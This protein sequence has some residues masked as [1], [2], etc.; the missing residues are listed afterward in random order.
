LESTSVRTA[1][2][3]FYGDTG[4]YP[5]AL[6]DLVTKNYLRRIPTDPVTDST[7][8]WIIVA[9]VD[10]QKGAVFDVKSGTP[11]KCRDGSLYRDW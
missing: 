10:A 5:A 9:P 6:N 3:K 8:T 7:T 1:V 11:G 2:D 4:K